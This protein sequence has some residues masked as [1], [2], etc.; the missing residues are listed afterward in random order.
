MVRL[1]SV[2]EED[3]LLVRWLIWHVRGKK[4]LWLCVGCGL[5]LLSGLGMVDL[6]FKMFNN[7][8]RAVILVF[9]C[10]GA[11]CSYDLSRWEVSFP[12]FVED[13]GN[14]CCFV[15]ILWCYIL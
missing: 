12:A 7:W 2:R 15:D 6:P 10:S 9:S 14:L 13:L 5:L 4:V 11:H 1:N 8:W 3:D